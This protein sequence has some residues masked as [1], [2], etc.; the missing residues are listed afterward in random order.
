M[1]HDHYLP[2][3]YLCLSVLTEGAGQ[4]NLGGSRGGD[5]SG[6][7]GFGGRGFKSSGGEASGDW[8]D[9]GSSGDTG[10]RFR[11]KSGGSGSKGGFGGRSDGGS[12]FGS[13][14]GARQS[15]DD[16]K[17]G[18]F[19]GKP[20]AGFGRQGSDKKGG[21]DGGFGGKAGGFGA[22]DTGGGEEDWGADEITPQAGDLGPS[23]SSAGDANR[24][25]SKKEAG[26]FSSLTLDIGETVDVFVVYTADPDHF[27]CQVIKNCPELEELMG[28]MNTFYNNVSESDLLLAR[29]DTGVPCAAKFEEDN[30]WYRAQVV[31]LG[32][33]EAEVQFVDYGNTQMIQTSQL[34]E[35]KPEFVTLKT[36]GLK[37]GLDGVVPTNKIWSQK[38]L[39]DFEDLTIDKHLVGRVITTGPGS[40]YL[41]DLENVDEKLNIGESMCAKGHCSLKT[42]KSP[43]KETPVENPYEIADLAVGGETAVYVA[44]IETPEQFW[45]QPVGTEDHLAE[46]AEKIQELYTTGPGMDLILGSLERGQKVVAR[47]SEDGAWYRGYVEKVIGE[48]CKV[49]FVDYGNSDTVAKESLRLPTDELLKEKSQAALC[50]LTGVRPLQSGNYTADAKDIFDSLVKDAAVKC[51]VHDV[52]NGHFSVELENDGVNVKQELITAAVLKAEKESSPSQSSSSSVSKDIAGNRALRYPPLD[53][54]HV[55]STEMVYI[56]HTDSVAS[57]WCQLAKLSD[58]LDDIMAKLEEHCVSGTEIGSFPT[59]MACGA[60]FSEDGQWYRAKVSAA[61]PDSVEVL[62]VDY[63]NTEKVMVS[64]ICLLTEELVSVPPLAVQCELENASKASNQLTAKFTE[65]VQDK[66]LKA[67]VKDIQDDIAVVSLELPTGESMGH[68]LELGPPQSGSEASKSE[69]FRDRAEDSTDVRPHVK[70]TLSELPKAGCSVFLS[71]VVSLA[72]FYVQKADQES[73]LTELMSC[74]EEHCGSASLLSSGSLKLGL[75][76]CAKFSEDNTWYR[77]R[78]EKIDGQNVTVFFVDYGNSEDTSIRNM[79]ALSEDLAKTPMFAIKCSLDGVQKETDCHSDAVI[80]KFEELTVDKE[81]FC[82]PVQSGYVKLKVDGESVANLLL[83]EDKNQAKLETEVTNQ[84]KSEARC[85]IPRHKIPKDTCQVYVSHISTPADF[86]V[87][88]V[89]EEEDLNRVMAELA[90]AEANLGRHLESVSVGDT[91]C[92]QYSEDESLYRA[93][94]VQKEG[95]MVEVLF[96]DY[97]NTEQTTTDKLWSLNKELAEKACFAVSCGLAGVVPV[98]GNWTEECIAFLE[99]AVT[100]KKLD[101]KFVGSSHVR[102]SLDGADVIEWLIEKGYAQ[103]VNDVPSPGKVKGQFTPQSVPVDSVGCYVSHTDEDGTIYLQLG[104]EEDILNRVV[105]EVQKLESSPALDIST[106]RRGE[107][108]C[109]RFSEDQS[110]YRAVVT[111]A[112]GENVYLRFVDYGNT[113]TVTKAD[114]LRALT[115]LHLVDPHLAYACR[116]RG[117]KSLTE[118]QV[119]LLTELT[120][121]KELTVTFLSHSPVYEVQLQDENQSDIAQLLGVTDNQSSEKTQEEDDQSA[122]ETEIKAEIAEQTQSV[123]GM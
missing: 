60:K 44:W 61:Y 91:V 42:S 29:P 105:E 76:C 19:G 22:S 115:E 17:G 83:A 30:Q 110:W 71:N 15:T 95:E 56:S 112:N 66:E 120:K 64:G 73:S 100:E 101:C 123:P 67:C 70:Y 49:R 20:S 37:C 86:H 12:G 18:G 85:F 2:N 99:T 1:T 68:L 116:L 98:K 45:V 87:Q 118:S 77:A 48:Q 31:S 53:L 119:V 80:A 90:E 28:E 52:K 51:K 35:L 103:R 14:G 121:D 79:R 122:Q 7:S 69:A 74:V 21:G 33:Q 46:L 40:S 89:L 43:V 10:G 114:D 58:Q 47:F 75:A 25:K 117:C 111:A 8:G 16:Q 6:G 50:K 88:F 23:V 32:Q 39:E 113:D 109:A 106:V 62:F 41:L 108:L 107:N 38:A 59:D 55:G 72:E 93:E 94:V 63:G 9:S 34:K 36:Q 102:L 81:L 4:R 104:C 54:I 97:G 27:Y 11:A 24:L 26:S 3:S 65:L 96:V 84:G 82:E 78:V 92:A 13:R 5:R 57:F